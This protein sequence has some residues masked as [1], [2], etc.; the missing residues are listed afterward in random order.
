MRRVSAGIENDGAGEPTSLAKHEMGANR[1][2]H[3]RH[4]LSE[5]VS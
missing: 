2:N 4:F 5:P 1:G 3:V